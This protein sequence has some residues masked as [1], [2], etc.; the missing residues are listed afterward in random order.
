MA[1]SMSVG[2]APVAR[3]TADIGRV[4]PDHR[5]VDVGCGPG[6]A[7]REARRRGAQ[8]TGVD[9]SRQMLR[10]A[11]W[12]TTVRRVSGLTLLLGS[13]ESLPLPSD[14]A[15]VLWAISSVHH[16]QD[17]AG[18][19]AEARRVLTPGGRLLLVERAVGPGTGWH[20]SHGLSAEG[21]ARLVRDVAEAGFL[22]VV[23][24]QRRAGRRQLVVVDAIAPPLNASSDEGGPM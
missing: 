5:V 10:L 12:I 15:T 24:L 14:S 3:A 7:L 17:V 13:A 18:G 16:W 22:E 21:A 23:T 11:R 6:A 9:P 19:L 4:G 2:R 1:I 20:A 8:A